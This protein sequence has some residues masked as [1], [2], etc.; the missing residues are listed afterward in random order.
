[1]VIY[2]FP[3]SEIVQFQFLEVKSEMISEVENGEKEG[4]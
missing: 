2:L 3:A 4:S 1:M